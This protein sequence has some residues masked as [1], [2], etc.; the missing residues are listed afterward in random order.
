MAQYGVCIKEE[1][2]HYYKE[3]TMPFDRKEYD[4]NRDNT[5]IRCNIC[6]GSHIVRNKKRHARTKK[7]V[8]AYDLWMKGLHSIVDEE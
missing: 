7:H 8:K 3:T 1:S 2:I 5:T 6:G 4:N